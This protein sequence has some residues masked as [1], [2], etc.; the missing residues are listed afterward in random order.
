MQKMYSQA[1]GRGFEPR[2]PLNKLKLVIINYLCAYFRAINKLFSP[3]KI[4]K[5][6]QNRSIKCKMFGKCLANF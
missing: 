3:Y 4:A 2:L 1:E 6:V 5:T